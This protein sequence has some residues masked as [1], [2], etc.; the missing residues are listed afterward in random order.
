MAI[1]Y[2]S[3]QCQHHKFHKNFLFAIT[4]DIAIFTGIS[5]SRNVVDFSPQI[6]ASKGDNFGNEITVEMTTDK[7]NSHSYDIP[8]TLL[9][10]FVSKSLE[11]KLTQ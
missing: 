1:P 8:E 3:L 5:A 2:V 10:L 4:K 9:F 11:N 7:M 6:K